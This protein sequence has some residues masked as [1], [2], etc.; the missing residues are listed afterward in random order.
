M[1]SSSGEGD[2]IGPVLRYFLLFCYLVMVSKSLGSLHWVGLMT[3]NGASSNRIGGLVTL[4]LDE[5]LNLAFNTHL[6]FGLL[7]K[8]PSSARRDADKA[9]V[10]TAIQIPLFNIIASN[11]MPG[12]L[13]QKN[14]AMFH[15]FLMGAAGF[16]IP[17][18]HVLVLWIASSPVYM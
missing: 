10:L 9:L 18:A 14:Y 8:F 15:A 11:V 2:T 3:M 7:W 1:G 17:P 5:L 13:K 4:A 6:C 12:F 16:A